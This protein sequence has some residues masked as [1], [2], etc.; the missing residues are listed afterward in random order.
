MIVVDGI[1]IQTKAASIG[2]NHFKQ[3]DTEINTVSNQKQ[4]ICYVIQAKLRYGNLTDASRVDIAMTFR[5]MHTHSSFKTLPCKI[6]AMIK[7]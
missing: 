4:L 2:H 5:A 1:T 6:S 3:T 7:S